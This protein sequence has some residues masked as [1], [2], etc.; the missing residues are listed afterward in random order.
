MK[1]PH[2]R[3]IDAHKAIE[4]AS[5]PKDAKIADLVLAFTK[6]KK[7][8][9]ELIY[10][11][12]LFVDAYQRTVM[13]ALVLGHATTEEIQEATGIPLNVIAAYQTYIFDSDVFRNELDRISWVRGLSKHVSADELKLLQAALTVGAKYLIWLITGRGSFTPVDVIRHSMNDAMFR[14][15]AHRSAPINSDIAK[16]ALL[17]IRTAERLAK[18]LQALDPQDIA[19]AEK[20]LRIALMY[21]ETTV[22]EETSGI[23]PENILH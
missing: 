2:H 19:E 14:G 9:P 23:T 22:N 3:V 15:M 13:D 10:A 17:W 8:K 18:T 1:D 12:D 20:Q 7:A 4:K 16:E 6:D 21:D 5:K 11:V